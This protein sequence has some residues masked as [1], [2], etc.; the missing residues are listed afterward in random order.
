MFCWRLLLTYSFLDKVK[1]L[2][3]VVFH[4]V[5][6]ATNEFTGSRQQKIVV[7]MKA[8][9]GEEQLTKNPLGKTSRRR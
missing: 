9:R 2:G 7:I 8:L 4:D 3:T 5:V 1:L 6:V